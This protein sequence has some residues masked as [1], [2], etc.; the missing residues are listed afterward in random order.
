MGKTGVRNTQ[1]AAA[2]S[3][4]GGESGTTEMPAKN[5]QTEEGTGLP[6]RT[7]LQ[8]MTQA[9]HFMSLFPLPDLVATV[10][11]VNNDWNEMMMALKFEVWNPLSNLSPKSNM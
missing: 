8:V 4:A 1:G 10:F 11:P 7:L 6:N 9:P 2:K 5:L 3:A